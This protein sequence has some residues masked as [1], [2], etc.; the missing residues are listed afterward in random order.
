MLISYFREKRLAEAELK[1]KQEEDS[2]LK[3]QRELV[4]CLTF[5]SKSLALTFGTLNKAASR[6]NVFLTVSLQAF[7]TKMSNEILLCR[8]RK[9]VS[10]MS[11]CVERGNLKNKNG[12]EK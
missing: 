2:R 6:N 8:M 10:K 11:I 1:R 3:K 12:K 5:V 9:P 7:I 4:Y